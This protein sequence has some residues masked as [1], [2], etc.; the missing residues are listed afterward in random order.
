MHGTWK[1]AGGGGSGLPNEFIG[2]ALLI[3]AMVGVAGAVQA[4]LTAIFVWLFIGVLVVVFAAVAGTVAFLLYRARR[5]QS[6][7]RIV[8]SRIIPQPAVY[9]L[10]GPERPAITP[11]AARQLHLHFHGTGPEQVAEILRR[12]E[13]PEP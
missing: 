1:T 4:A 5:P 13:R 8:P 2:L 3:A 9:E 12:H 10:P 6:Q 11:P 7:A